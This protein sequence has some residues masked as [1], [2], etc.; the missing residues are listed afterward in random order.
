MNHRRSAD[1]PALTPY[2]GIEQRGGFS[3]GAMFLPAGAYD[4]FGGQVAIHRLVDA[5]YDRFEAD[6]I[7]RPLFARDLTNERAKVKLFFEGWFGGSPDYFNADWRHGLRIAH[8]SAAIRAGRHVP[9]HRDLLVGLERVQRPA[10]G[11][12]RAGARRTRFGHRAPPPSSEATSPRRGPST[13]RS[14]CTPVNIRDLT[15]PSGTPVNVATS[16]CV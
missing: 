9:L 5:L 14:R 15:V 1:A 7:L 6:P 16:R 13:L 12:F 8:R 4:A 2:T 10:D 11:L 3:P